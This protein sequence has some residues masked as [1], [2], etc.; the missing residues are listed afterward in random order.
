ME[1]FEKCLILNQENTST[2]IRLLEHNLHTAKFSNESLNS[3]LKVGQKIKIK[4]ITRKQ[5]QAP[6]AIVAHCRVIATQEECFYITFSN[7]LEMIL[8]SKIIEKRLIPEKEEQIYLA[9][10]H[11]SFISAPICFTLIDVTKTSFL[12]EIKQGQKLFYIPGVEL[13]L[14]LCIPRQRHISISGIIHDVFRSDDKIIIELIVKDLKKKPLDQ[15]GLYLLQNLENFDFN[16]LTRHHLPIPK[17]KGKLHCAAV[18]TKDEYDKILELRRDAYTRKKGS[19]IN[20]KNDL[21]S[22]KDKYDL[23][24]YNSIIKLGD[25]AIGTG[26]SV[27]NYGNYEQSEIMSLG[28]KPPDFILKGKFIEGSRFATHQ[29]FRGSDLFYLLISFTFR[30]ASITGHKYLLA[31]CEDKLLPFYKKLGAKVFKEKIIHPWENIS[32]N[33]VYFDV[34]KILKQAKLASKIPIIS[35]KFKNLATDIIE[36]GHDPVID[37]KKHL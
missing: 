20:P 11:P 8:K 9:G 27:F 32:L 16:K 25:M 21:E 1:L 36:S 28:F 30:S 5:I 14:K 17:L 18:S 22:F 35:R 31:D 2:E 13:N 37:L 4:F 10:S 23:C 12:L 19:T 33:I 6:C 7:N 24:A 3:N 26:R 29:N 15:I 34:H